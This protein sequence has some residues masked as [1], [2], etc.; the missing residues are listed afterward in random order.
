[1]LQLDIESATA[2]SDVDDEEITRISGRLKWSSTTY[3]D[4][5]MCVDLKYDVLFL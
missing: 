2:L 5:E 4:P 3:L 1:M